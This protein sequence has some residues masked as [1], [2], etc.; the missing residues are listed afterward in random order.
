MEMETKTRDGKVLP[1]PPS[2]DAKYMLVICSA[3][4]NYLIEKLS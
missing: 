4:I 1:M 2:E 3:F